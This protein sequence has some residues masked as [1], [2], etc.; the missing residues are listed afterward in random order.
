MLEK[1]IHRFICRAIVCQ[2]SNYPLELSEVQTWFQTKYS[3]ARKFTGKNNYWANKYKNGSWW[4][5]DKA[6]DDDMFADLMD[7]KVRFVELLI[8]ELKNEQTH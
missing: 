7:L 1:R 2:R 5:V 4:N 6:V 8:R 3:Q